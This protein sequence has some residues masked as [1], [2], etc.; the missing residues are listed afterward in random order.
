MNYTDL[1]ILFFGIC[2][3]F[4]IVNLIDNGMQ[5]KMQLYFVLVSLFLLI[6]YFSF[7]TKSE[8]KY[9]NFGLLSLP[10]FVTC[11]YNILNLAS[12]KYNRREFR[13]RI[14]GSRNIDKDNTNSLDVL[15]SLLLLMSFFVW[16][17]I[18][19]LVLQNI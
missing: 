9:L 10:I 2:Y 7:F 15:F 6:V 3:S 17:L 12:W 18:I 5:I 16:P 11:L 19:I 8:Y 4:F 13:L 14:K 1:G